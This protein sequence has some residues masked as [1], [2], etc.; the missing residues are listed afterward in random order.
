MPPRE[1]S[2]TGDAAPCTLS[3]E[4]AGL[5]EKYGGCRQ[6]IASTPKCNGLED[7]SRC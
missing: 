7:R 2:S 5:V 4:M 1:S 6:G 3:D